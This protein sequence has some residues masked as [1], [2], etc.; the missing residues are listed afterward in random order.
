MNIL[1]SSAGR[2][3][4]LVNAFKKE[5]AKVN[6]KSKVY[7]TDLNPNFSTACFISDKHFK[8]RSIKED[9]AIEELIDICKK[10][11]ISLIIPTI[12]TELLTLSSNIKEFKANGI[13]IVISDLEIIKICRNKRSTHGFFDKLKIPRCNEYSK[14]KLKFPLF[15]KPIDGSMSRGL[16]KIEK[17]SD[18]NYNDLND[19]NKMLL[20]YI[21]DQEFDE[22]TIDMYFNKN[23]ELICLVPRKRIE[24]RSG[25]VSKS[26]TDKKLTFVKDFFIDE[27]HGLRGCITF[28]VF[29][30]K[31]NLNILGIEI[32]PRFG[33]GYPLTYFAGANYPEMIIK[34]YI[35]NEKL[36][37]YF[38]DWS[39][40]MLMLRYDKEIIIQC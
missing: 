34:E 2:R 19:D 3:V 24:V 11:K 4:S 8:V 36:T 1:I 37:K 7:T 33:G 21:S 14:F 29:L 28:Q 6:S 17:K 9:G 25:E 12:D 5:L 30:H 16:K 31:K 39:D 32:N 15:I 20:E 18:L 26:I 10:N 35:L 38:E 23:S 40:K 22:Y 13:D 27:K